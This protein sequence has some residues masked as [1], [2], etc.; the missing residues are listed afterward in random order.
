MI[1][2]PP[3]S[4]LFP[5][6]T[7]FRSELSEHHEQF[8]RALA[9]LQMDGF[10]AVRHGRGRPA[11]DRAKVARAFL[12]KAV[13]HF[14]NTRALLD[15]LALDTVLRRL[16][17]WETA[18]QVPDESAFSRAFA[19]FARSEFAQRVHAALVQ[20]TQSERLVGHIVRDASAIEVREKPGPKPP[21]APAA[22][23]PHRKA[24]AAK[25]PEQMT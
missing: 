17:G 10:V 9:L 25:R 15:R 12:A 2:R 7:L 8:V 14:P 11:H 24:G 4:T 20:R 5:Y 6:T 18:A 23:R 22:R 16:C 13:F 3:R 19:E 21:A 1:R